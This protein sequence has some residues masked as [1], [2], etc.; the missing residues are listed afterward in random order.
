MMMDMYSKQSE[1]ARAQWC[2]QQLEMLR[3]Y[4]RPLRLAAMIHPPHLMSDE[5]HPVSLSIGNSV[6]LYN[7]YDDFAH[8][9][10]R[11]KLSSWRE[12]VSGGLE[13]AW[14]EHGRSVARCTA[15]LLLAGA[16]VAGWLLVQLAS[17]GVHSV[18]A[19]VVALKIGGVQ[20]CAVGTRASGARAAE[21]SRRLKSKLRR[22]FLRNP[23]KV[24][25]EKQLVV[26]KLQSISHKMTEAF[27]TRQRRTVSNLAA[28]THPIVELARSMLKVRAGA[29][30]GAVGAAGAAG[31]GFVMKE[32][33]FE[34]RLTA[35]TFA[36]LGFFVGEVPRTYE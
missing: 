6:S 29:G 32:R 3:E 8:V 27:S 2:I 15:A 21:L 20:L 22:A 7:R 25:H 34:E 12:K 24:R 17:F 18:I 35:Q 31:A 1:R 28:A 33:A 19:A 5:S 23:A 14:N 16:R 13:H 11:K 4:G 36:E 10:W 30:A 9:T 26:Q